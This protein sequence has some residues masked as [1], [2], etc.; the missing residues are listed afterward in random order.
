MTCDQK[1]DLMV[2]L[3][4]SILKILGGKIEDNN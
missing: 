4:E 1:L 2:K 3:L